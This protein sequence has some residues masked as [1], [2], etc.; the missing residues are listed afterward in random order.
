MRPILVTGT[1]RSGTSLVAGMLFYS[2]VFMGDYFLKRDKHNPTGYFEDTEFGELDEKRWKG[3]I[4]ESQWED[5]VKELLNSRKQ[6]VFGFPRWGWKNPSSGLFIRDYIKLCN[7]YV[8]H[9]KRDKEKTLES[10]NKMHWK[11]EAAE[12]TYKEKIEMMDG[13]DCL[14]INFEDLLEN[15]SLEFGRILGYTQHRPGKVKLRKALNH[16]ITKNK[17]FETEHYTNYL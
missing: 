13:I 6:E 9:C 5:A 2:G 12:R 1:Q 10:M 11:D 8:I 4:N 16:V 7:P 14:E 3:V 15:P 17:G